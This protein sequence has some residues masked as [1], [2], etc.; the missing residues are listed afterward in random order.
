MHR[1]LLGLTKGDPEVDHINHD[2]LDN[3]RSNLRVVT[4]SQNAQN[5]SAHKDSM[6]S[7][8]RGVTYCI[9]H[10]HWI[11]SAMC[12]GKKYRATFK[13]EQEAADAAA[14]YR[15]QH[16]PYSEEASA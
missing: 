11:A 3:R 8:H 10:R 15:E 16:M 4:R 7:K 12:E 13:T 5:G 6:Y 9:R 14:R 2:R 1:D